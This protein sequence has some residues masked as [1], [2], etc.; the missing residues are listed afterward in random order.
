MFSG[1]PLGCSAWGA[2]STQPSCSFKQLLAVPW[3]R[4]PAPCF[5]PTAAF[6]GSFSEI[7]DVT[8]WKVTSA[9]FH[10]PSWLR[11]IACWVGGVGCSTGIKMG[12]IRRSLLGQ[13]Q[14][15]QATGV[16]SWSM[17]AGVPL[18]SAFWWQWSHLPFGLPWPACHTLV[19]ACIYVSASPA[20]QEELRL[21]RNTGRVLILNGCKDS[22]ILMHFFNILLKFWDSC[23]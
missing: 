21:V 23:K 5:I 11:W 12:T 18:S 9:F 7:S 3:M 19:V 10:F 6:P 14:A 2:V 1:D 15:K 20:E 4:G 8:G 16:F 13:V 22:T 17:M